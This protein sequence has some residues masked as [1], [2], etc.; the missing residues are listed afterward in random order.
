VRQAI[1]K[2]TAGCIRLLHERTILVLTI[3]FCLGVVCM[4]WYVS[5]LQ[6]NLIASTVLQDA[7][8]YSQALGE[9]RTLY[10][11]E[12]VDTVIKRGIEVTHDHATREGAIPLPATFTMLI[13]KRIGAHGSGA[14]TR[15]YSPYPFPWRQEEGGLQDAFSQEAWSSLQYH[16]D[17]PFYRFEEFNGIRSL[18]YATADLMRPSCVDCHNVHPASPKTDWKEGDVRGVLEVILPLDRAMAQ[19]YVGLKG[20]F[21]LMGV[22]SVLGLAGLALMIGRLRRTSAD[23]TQRADALEGEIAERQGAEA[24]LRES[25]ER[26]RHIINAAA[27]A[28]ISIDEAGLVCEFNRAAEQIFGFRQP[29]VLGKPLTAIIPERLRAQHMAGLQR[30]LATGQR[31]LPRWQNIELPGLTKDG[32]EFPLEVSF[33]L[34]EAGEK[35][36]LTGV[37]RDITE[38]KRTEVELQ[39]T[40]EAA[41][42]ATQAKSEF[43]ANMSHELRTPMNAIIGFTRLVMRRSKD[44]LPPRE[45]ENLGKI[46]ISSEH[47][48][49]LINDILDLSKIEAGRMEVHLA[50]MQVEELV[51]TCLRTVEPMIKSERLRLA[52]EIEADLPP[53][54][55]DQDKLRQILVNLLSNAVKF[56][57]EGSVTVSARRQDGTLALAVTDTGI[58]IPADKIELIFEEFRQVES[59]AVRTYGGTG[60]GLTISRRLARLLGGD[61]IVQSTDGVGSTFTITIPFGS[62]PAQLTMQG[63]RSPYQEQPADQREVDK[64]VLAI[65]DDPDVIYL[66]HENL[67]EAGYRVVGAL[68]GREGLAKARELQPLAI[69]LDILMPQPDGWQVLHELKADTA[70][71]AIPVIVLSI[72]DNKTLGY[73]LG[74]CDYLIKPFDR[75]AILATLAHVPPRQG[76]LLVVDDDPRVMDLVCQ[77]LEG[78]PYEIMS[79]ADGQEALEAIDHR[80]PDVILLDLLMPRI[81]G[82]MLIEQIQQTLQLRQIPIIVLTAKTLTAAEQAQLDQR[83]RTVIQKRGLD[84]E[85]LIQELR[86]LLQAYRGPTSP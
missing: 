25:E 66:L 85:T 35:K 40:K 41:E 56:T 77:L 29:E 69:T 65:D 80:R 13:G 72:V 16:P 44:F 10:T 68:N 52:K 21:A 38:R 64:I 19:T 15:L 24:A 1:T 50:D 2:L 20:S 84:R 62:S 27:D 9:F 86:G 82:F 76:R 32:R 31:H 48:L 79:A 18:R 30:Y 59:S 3:L 42:A 51:D 63:T 12:V 36:F 71:R 74:A 55:T 33:S 73:R 78:E 5:H 75:D 22:M 11:S 61:L 67:A 45:H 8:L 60:L 23:L 43:L 70:T 53:L 17:K 46:L 26:Y 58:G 14:Q 39:Q 34:L 81:D 49:A 37:L 83:V 57:A 6:S 7:S 47:L 4:L 28:I 54:F